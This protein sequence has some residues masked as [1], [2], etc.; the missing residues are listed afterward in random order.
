MYVTK[1]SR[2]QFLDIVIV[3]DQINQHHYTHIYQKPADTTLYSLHN[4]HVPKLATLNALLQRA[5][6]IY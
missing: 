4:S 2:L 3:C 1:N 6:K 5:L